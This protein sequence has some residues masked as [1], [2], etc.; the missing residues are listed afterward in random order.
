MQ[1]R[2]IVAKAGALLIALLWAGCA[3]EGVVP[4]SEAPG[5][6]DKVVLSEETL[7][8][9]AIGATHALEA[10]VLDAENRP[11]R[12]ARVHWSSTDP[13][14]ASV[15]P[16]GLVTAIAHGNADIVATYGA[17]AAKAHVRVLPTPKELARI[18]IV[19]EA[20]TL[21]FLGQTIELR[22]IA[23]DA[24]G[25]A[26]AEVLASWE[27]EDGG[28]AKVDRLGNLV[29]V[30]MGQTRVHATILDGSLSSEA[31]IT[32]RPIPSSLVFLDRPVSTT[33]GTPQPT[34][35]RVE[36]R[37]AG[38]HPVHTPD[39][40]VDLEA[41]YGADSLPLGQRPIEGGVATFDAPLLERAGVEV[42]LVA[43][44]EQ[45][46]G[47]SEPF[48]V[49]HAAP[50]RLGFVD[51]PTSLEARVPHPLRV[52]VVDA[53]G[54]PVPSVDAEIRLEVRTLDPPEL[55]V[56]GADAPLAEGGITEFTI[57]VDRPGHLSFGA[58]AE[59]WPE[60]ETGVLAA[61]YL[62]TALEAGKNHSC[63]LLRTGEALCFGANEA[64]QL[65]VP[66]LSSLPLPTP[67]E[68]ELA[69]AAIATGHAYSCGISLE[70]EAYCWGDVPGREA[71]P[72][73]KAISLP[74]APISIAAGSDHLCFLTQEG[75]AHCLGANDHGQLGNGSTTASTL[76]V[77]AHTPPLIALA[78]GEA[79]SCGLDVDGDLWCWGRND[80][81][82]LGGASSQAFERYPIAVE[83]LSFVSLSLGSAHACGVDENQRIQC[84]GRS[85]LGQVGDGGSERNVPPRTVA[86]ERRF[87]EV[88]LGRDHSCARTEAGEIFCWGADEAGQL[89]NTD[90]TEDHSLLPIPVDLPFEGARFTRLAV[91]AR[92]GC[93]LEEGGAAYCWGQGAEGQLGAG[94]DSDRASP[95][96]VTGTL[97]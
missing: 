45:A 40:V 91:G 83:K 94:D 68:S 92:H 59:S 55:V 95:T 56:V 86:S 57:E 73:P 5:I 72:E 93:A 79:F 74:A 51:L 80:E 70:E 75:D 6:A 7:G 46:V 63:G 1:D 23:F 71:T 66:K 54:N 34:S 58:V 18:G 87:V 12:D 15:D 61:R 4:L 26:L 81:G 48:S 32:V 89:G 67:L 20:P 47:E 31:T 25:E 11:L 14:V 16:S 38:G 29:S 65:G 96:P 21:T 13:A 30:G 85:G 69:F 76:P 52:A 24:R 43:R 9:T 97:P 60:A 37:D 22:A 41:A 50:E 2:V 62:F 19:P 42:R 82:Q 49:G 17:I 10:T 44:W 8:F 36:A 88:A 27:V 90:Q 64:G 78:A 33:A 53:F 28:V 77:Q 35:I 84:W 3:A 39:L